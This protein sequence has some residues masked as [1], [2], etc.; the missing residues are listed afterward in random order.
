MPRLLGIDIPEQKRVE[1]ALTNIYGIGKNNVFQVLKKA[2]VDKGRRAK[3]LTGGEV[4]R[5]Q[6]AIET[7]P[8][9]GTLRKIVSEDIKR[10]SQIGSYR[11]LRH[12]AGLPARGQRTRTN[13]RT[14]RGKR[15][16]VGAL[17]KKFLQ[18]MEVSKKEKEKKEKTK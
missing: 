13:A 6:K 16:T 9:E 4:V 2:G 8:T 1:A 17:R 11:G 15:M 12:Q 5:L 7:F 10:F 18:K 3:D 14:K